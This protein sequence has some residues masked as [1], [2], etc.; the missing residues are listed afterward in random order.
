MPLDGTTVLAALWVVAFLGGVLVGL[1]LPREPPHWWERPW[2]TG[3]AP[4]PSSGERMR[5]GR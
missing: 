4:E 5:S 1:G 3:P 2:P